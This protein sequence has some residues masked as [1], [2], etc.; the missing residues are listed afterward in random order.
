MRADKIEGTGIAQHMI[1]MK[2]AAP[3]D[4]PPEIQGAMIKLG[5][6]EINVPKAQLGF[7]EIQLAAVEAHIPKIHR[8][9]MENRVPERGG[10][11]RELRDTEIRIAV[12]KHVAG[13]DILDFHTVIVR[14]T[15]LVQGE[16][17]NVQIIQAHFLPLPQGL[18]D[19]FLI[20]ASE[21]LPFQDDSRRRNKADPRRSAA[22]LLI[23]LVKRLINEIDHVIHKAPRYFPVI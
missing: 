16:I 13:A 6:V 3:D 9:A 5:V 21:F 23:V 4:H 12:E 8:C 11:S 10:G 2:I 19:R 7:S 17:P 14:L 1:E 20:P 22:D 15:D 18:I